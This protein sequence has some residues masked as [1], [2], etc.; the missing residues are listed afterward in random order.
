M[1]QGCGMVGLPLYGLSVLSDGP[2]PILEPEEPE[3][4]EHALGLDPGKSDAAEFT[5]RAVRTGRATVTARATFEVHLGYPGPAYWSG[6]SAG[7]PLVIAVTDSPTPATPEV[8]PTPTVELTSSR[9]ITVGRVGEEVTVEGTVVDATSFSEG[10]KF[11]LDDGTRQ[12]VLL[13]WH[14]VYDDCWD[15]AEL[16]LGARVRAT[17]QVSQYE[18]QLQIEPRLGG[19]VKAIEGA[20]A[21]APRREI[22]SISGADEGQRVMLEGKVVRTEGLPSAVKVFLGDEGPAAQGEIVVFIWRNVLDRIADNT[23]LGTAGS[24]VRVVGTVQVY[25]SN[26]EIVPALPNDVTVL[27]IP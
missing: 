5:L 7:G 16:N 4:V 9:S 19:D 20:V 22:G 21:Q 6:S 1:N 11:T 25:R 18:G 23:G 12:I 13:L 8:T 3:P 10:F 2:E 14:E 27:E 24:R 17:G 26:L 15:A